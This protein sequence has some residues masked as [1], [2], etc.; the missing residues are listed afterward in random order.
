MLYRKQL[1]RK[2]K[3]QLAF[4]LPN[5]RV[6]KSTVMRKGQPAKLAVFWCNLQSKSRRPRKL[7][8]GRNGKRWGRGRGQQ[9]VRKTAC[10]Q[11]SFNFE[12]FE[13]TSERRTQQTTFISDW[14]T[15]CQPVSGCQIPRGYELQRSTVVYNAAYLIFVRSKKIS[16]SVF[17]SSSRSS[18][19]PKL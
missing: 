3:R 16:L 11:L 6:L 13:T 1:L 9:A 15:E 17:H 14:P 18:A 4:E 7:N 2:R 10:N 8:R 12:I 19:V 5:L